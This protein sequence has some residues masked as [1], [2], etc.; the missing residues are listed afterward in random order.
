MLR[1]RTAKPKPAS[2]EPKDPSTVP[3]AVLKPAEPETTADAPVVDPEA[4]AVPDKDS[5]LPED[6]EPVL[7]SEAALGTGPATGPADTSKPDPVERVV[8]ESSPFDDSA[9]VPAPEARADGP[10]DLPGPLPDVPPMKPSAE[11]SVPAENEIMGIPVR[12]ESSPLKPVHAPPVPKPITP[13]TRTTPPPRA[14]TATARPRTRAGPK[15]WS[16]RWP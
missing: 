3:D 16:R 8:I 11:T 9:D 13:P 1:R 14:P 4:P 2:P 7:T 5:F 6:G 15:T 12:T 10:V